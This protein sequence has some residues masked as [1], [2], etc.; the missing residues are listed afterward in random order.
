M[1]SASREAQIRSDGAGR[2][3]DK[4]VG[5]RIFFV[6]KALQKAVVR[7]SKETTNHKSHRRMPMPGVGPHIKLWSGSCDFCEKPNCHE[8]R[9]HDRCRRRRCDEVTGISTSLITVD[10][11]TR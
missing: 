2:S 3:D 8:G 11:L 10:I 7:T 1:S 6:K 5:R 9:A 4:F